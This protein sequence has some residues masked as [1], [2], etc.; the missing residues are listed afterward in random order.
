MSLCLFLVFIV[1]TSGVVV[2]KSSRSRILGIFCDRRQIVCVGVRREL[3][4]TKLGCLFFSFGGVR[5]RISH[6]PV[7]MKRWEV[8]LGRQV[9]CIILVMKAFLSFYEA[10][11]SGLRRREETIITAAGILSNV[12]VNRSPA[13]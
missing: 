3:Q 4:A 12:L 6:A 1:Y 10:C 2:A 5:I 8:G 9:F 11:S 13:L 7:K